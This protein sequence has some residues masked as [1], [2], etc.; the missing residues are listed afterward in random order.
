MAGE[1]RVFA[2]SPDVAGRRSLRP[3]AHE[4]SPLPPVLYGV[5][6][7]F[8]MTRWADSTMTRKLFAKMVHLAALCGI[9]RH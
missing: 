3:Q 9:L 4:S 2:V 8:M 5:R 1:Q 6:H 7:G